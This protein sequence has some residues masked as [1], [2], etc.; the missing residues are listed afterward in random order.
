ME[1]AKPFGSSLLG[2]D[3]FKQA[4]CAVAVESSWKWSSKLRLSCCDDGGAAVWVVCAIG[5][6]AEEF[7][8]A[9]IG[10]PA[11]VTASVKGDSYNH[12]PILRKK[13]TRTRA[14]GR[15]WKVLRRRV[16]TFRK[17]GP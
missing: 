4:G 5:G 6:V 8:A 11:D 3:A 10:D 13:V 12:D 7:V 9:R 15:S 2:V 14:R 17:N 1:G 16:R